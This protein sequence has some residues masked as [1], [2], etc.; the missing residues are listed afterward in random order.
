MEPGAQGPSLRGWPDPQAPRPG[1]GGH[2]LCKVLFGTLHL[3]SHGYDS[4]LVRRQGPGGAQ[5]NCLTH[6]RCSRPSAEMKSHL[7]AALCP[8]AGIH[9]PG[10]PVPGADRPGSAQGHRLGGL[11]RRWLPISLSW[12]GRSPGGGR[13]HPLLFQSL[14]SGSCQCPKYLRNKEEADHSSRSPPVPS[15]SLS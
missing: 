5:P 9:M 13:P 12:A 3:S 14:A 2:S 10:D 8:L 1:G 4:Y 15:P 7:G 11:L 6:C